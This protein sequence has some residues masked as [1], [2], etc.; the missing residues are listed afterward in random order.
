MK[1]SCIIGTVLM[2][3]FC[4]SL[5]TAAQSISGIVNSYYKITAVNT[6]T[7]TLTL[8][9]TTGLSPGTKVLLIQMKGATMDSSNTA[10]FG[11][12]IA[13]NNAGNYE[14]NYICSVSGNDVVLQL[15]MLNNYDPTKEAQMVTVPVY[16]SVTVSDTVTSS[17]WDTL[18]ETGG[19]VALEATDTIYLNST[20][21][22]S[23]QG[24]T[25]GPLVNFAVPPFNCSW[26]VNVTDYFMNIPALTSPA[27]YNTG[28][29]KGEGIADSVTN[30]RF[31]RGN[32]TSGGGGGNNNNTG[33]A[34]GGNFGA[35][36]NGGQ[37][38][39]ETFFDCH[40][41]NPGIGGLSLSA[42]GYS[43]AQNRIFVGGGGGSGHENNGVG[44]PGG[45]GGGII[46]ITAPVITGSGNALLA[47][48]VSPIN[49]GN[50]NPLVAEGD[51]GGGG[52]AGGTVII[53]AAQVNGSIDVEVQGARGSDASNLV[54]DCT[55][56]GGGGGGGV[57]WT[58]GASI[59][60]AISPVINGGNNGVVSAG[61]GDAAC[62]GAANSA[63]PGANGNAQTGYVAPL[64]TSGVCTVLALADLA[65]FTGSLTDYGSQLSWIMNTTSDIGSYRLERSTDHVNYSV[66]DTMGNNGKKLF[67][68]SDHIFIEGT[69]YYRLQLVFNNQSV[70]YSAIVVLNRE[71]NNAL[72][73]SGIQPN[74]V[75]DGL[76]IILFAKTGGSV[77]IRIYN[78]LGQ[79]MQA[80]NQNINNGYTKI[81]MP[82]NGLPSGTYILFV[83]GENVQAV[84]RFIKED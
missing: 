51:G 20:I 3:I 35:G 13:I 72:Q 59:P 40:G 37:R 43:I 10:T 52:G 30:G 57:V 41:K 26:A 61:S 53:N 42:Y 38:T 80:L 29:R 73:I 71:V 70:A 56:P 79:Q 24:F 74:P 32:Q 25:G 21:D 49:P 34:G 64:G 46:I 18:A 31:G 17:P 1:N 7:N 9:T 36:G 5:K 22:V 67:N 84:K 69:A 75:L 15:Q 45:N 55:G 4:T 11:N 81:S 60:V 83:Q 58:Q 23:G 62:R 47:N 8:N 19:I 65:S 2:T 14:F 77:N 39:N 48:G 33:G 66:I 28:G 54:T 76:N 50:V 44:L 63:T 16:S 68:F 78:I 27:Y 12:I 82:V 6:G